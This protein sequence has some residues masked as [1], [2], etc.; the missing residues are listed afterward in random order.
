MS[1]LRVVC[2]SDTHL[3]RAGGLPLWCLRR[4]EGA[5]LIVHAGDL[6]ALPVLEQLERLAPTVAVRGN[7]DAL[8]LKESLPARKI[9]E[10][11]G[12]RIGVLHDP[13]PALGRTDR[14]THAFLDCGAVVYGHTHVPEIQRLSDRLVLNPG[15]PTVPR[16]TLGATML[17]LAISSD[18]AIDPTFVTP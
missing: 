11:G 14:L 7:M 3:R 13:G 17:E 5:D 12:A 1:A 18:G 9:A 15:R 2:L 16:S 6:V 8:V 4:L 10:I